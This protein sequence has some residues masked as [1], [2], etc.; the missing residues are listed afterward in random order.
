MYKKK[1]FAITIAAALALAG[2]SSGSPKNSP[3]DKIVTEIKK[4]VEITFWHAMLGEQQKALQQLTDDFMKQNKNIKVTLQNQ[5]TY[6]DLQQKL[7]ATMASPKNLPTITQAYPGW[8]LNPINENKVMDLNP[9]IKNS[10][11]KFDDIDDILPSLRA[12]AELNGKLY[13]MPFNKSTEV[14]WYNK[15]LFDELNLKVP[16]TYDEL[17][18][19]AKTIYEKKGIPGAGFDSLS[20]FYTTYLKS[21]GKDLDS[22]LD[23]TGTESVKAAQY[24]LDGIKGGYFRTAGTDNFLSGPF[25]N[26]KVGMYLGSTAGEAFIKQGVGNKFEV[27]AARYPTTTSI[28]QGMD[29]YVFDSASPEQKT[30]AYLYI[31]FLT[32]K[33]SQIMWAVKSG[34][35]PIRESAIKSKEY[36]DSGSLLAP[37]LADATKNMYVIKN[38]KGADDAFREANTVMQGILA[39]K[40]T[41]VKKAMESFSKTYKTFW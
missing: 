8:L 22:K 16:T 28:S 29:L 15:T 30:A 1:I 2:C 14:L 13:G 34:Y 3:D 37:I 31:K 9:Y 24:Y 18:E 10:A 6:P 41:D 32:S 38:I 17:A 40:N 35:L 20:G 5:S 39:D 33:E 7:T 12:D 19:T 23:V 4:P 21:E 27:G 11:L 26:E 36:T 25:A